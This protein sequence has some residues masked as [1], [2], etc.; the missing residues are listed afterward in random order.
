M[1]GRRRASLLAE[2][3]PCPHCLSALLCPLVPSGH[4]GPYSRAHGNAHTHP[5]SQSHTAAHC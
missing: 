2:A 3:R 5:C 1:P 4:N